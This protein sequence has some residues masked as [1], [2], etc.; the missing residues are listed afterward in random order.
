MAGWNDELQ[1]EMPEVD[2]RA[3]TKYGSQR[4]V[5][6]GALRRRGT[7][8]TTTTS[9][10]TSTRP[11]FTNTLRTL[12]SGNNSPWQWNHWHSFANIHRGSF[13][14]YRLSMSNYCV[15]RRRKMGRKRER[16]KWIDVTFRLT[17]FLL[18]PLS[19]FLRSYPYKF[20]S[21]VQRYEWHF[22]HG[23]NIGAWG[24]GVG[25]RTFA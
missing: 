4:L 7:S 19:R 21:V 25:G 8:S 17:S 2:E 24:I 11:H 3:V 16:E 18:W 10:S 14:T 12:E 5:N 9:T 6:N 15:S 23:S 1:R 13:R 22:W 20:I